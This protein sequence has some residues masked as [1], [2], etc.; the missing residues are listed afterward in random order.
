[1]WTH[2]GYIYTAWGCTEL[3]KISRDHGLRTELR[4]PYQTRCVREGLIFMHID[5]SGFP[6]TYRYL[7]CIGHIPLT[8]LHSFESYSIDQDIMKAPSLH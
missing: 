3:I 8:Y 4:R 5:H 7:N 6:A 1:M 2:V